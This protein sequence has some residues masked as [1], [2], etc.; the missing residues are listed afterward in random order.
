MAGATRHGHPAGV[1]TSARAT[2]QQ[3][4]AQLA[5]EG[6]VADAAETVNRRCPLNATPWSVNALHSKR[7]G[8]ALRED[9]GTVNIFARALGREMTGMQR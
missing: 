6:G 7:Y 1:V 2:R 4:A 9:T 3:R 8:P 5:E